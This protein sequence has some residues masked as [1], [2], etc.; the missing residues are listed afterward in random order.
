MNEENLGAK[1]LQLELQWENILNQVSKG[2]IERE[3]I[4][5][6]MYELNELDKQIYKIGIEENEIC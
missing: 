6:I 2:N 4:S 3:K 1:K 5:Q